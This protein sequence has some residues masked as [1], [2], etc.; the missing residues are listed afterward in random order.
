[1]GLPMTAM[2]AGLRLGEMQALRVESIDLAAGVIHV[3]R[4]WDAREGEIE[5]K[6][7]AGRRKVPIPAALRDHL[8]DQLAHLGRRGA[9]LVFGRTPARPFD[10]STVQGR[11]DKAWSKAGLERVTPHE[12][13]H[14]FASLMIAA[15]VNAK[16]LSTFMGH[17]TISITLDRYGHLFPGSEG[18]AAQ[19]LDGYLNAQEERA[20]ARARAAETVPTGASTGASR[21][22]EGAE[23]A[24]ASGKGLRD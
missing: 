11:A 12:C 5:L 10:S 9:E 19:L 2:Y 18:E 13:R 7:R 24:L 6:S 3:E 23:T 22:P 8:L 21:S 1:M 14:T 4:G 16:A 15:G 17:T 20:A